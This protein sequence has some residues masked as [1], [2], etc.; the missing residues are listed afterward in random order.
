MGKEGL[1]KAEEE[2]EAAKKAHDQEIPTDIL[3]KFRVPDV[4]SIV[5]IPVQTL[6]EPGDASSRKLA[7][8]PLK[9][10]T[11]SKIIEADG[12]ALPFFVEY[13][14]VKVP[15]FVIVSQSYTDYQSSRT[16]F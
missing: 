11:L 4:K 9:D 5:W 7:T 15:S 6:Q 10:N 3:K 8:A 14:H 16:S 1:K 12:P 13:D 2:L